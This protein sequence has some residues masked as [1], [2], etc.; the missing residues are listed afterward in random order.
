[1]TSAPRPDRSWALFP[2]GLL[3]FERVDPG[4]PSRL[5]VARVESC[6][7]PECS[8]REVGLRAVAVDIGEDF[9]PDDLVRE[10]LR[11]RLASA[12]AMNA[13]LD[14]DLGSVVPD[15]YEGRVPL[16]DDWA[17]YAQS[18][19]DG[20]LLDALHGQWLGAKGMKSACR[21]DWEPRDAGDLVGWHKAHPADRRDLYL[22]DG[23]RF[24]AEELYCVNSTCTCNEALVGFSPTTRGS[25]DVGTLRV[26]I[27]TLEIVERNVHFKRAALLDRLWSA[28]SARHRH[29]SERLAERSRQMLDLA[30]AHAQP[31]RPGTRAPGGVG[32]DQPCP[33]DSGKKYKRCCGARAR[34]AD[35][36][37]RG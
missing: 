36:A 29:L 8:C 3:V 12:E 27:P 37:H 19:I 30:S 25:P 21:T 22:D 13:Q 2:H 23:K 24:V 14:I 9:N 28:F 15:D 1:M 16:S 34:G 35:H 20:E 26:R 6:T 32:R 18:Q 33:C 5:L 31:R 7:M 4:G 17:T 10:D 11:A